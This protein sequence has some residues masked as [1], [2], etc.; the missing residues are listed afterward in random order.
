MYTFS[1]PE[2]PATKKQCMSCTESKGP[3]SIYR[4]SFPAYPSKIPIFDSCV[5]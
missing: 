3:N 2:I 4:L 5:K 1:M